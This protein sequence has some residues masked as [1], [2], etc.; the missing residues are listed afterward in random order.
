MIL[1]QESDSRRP[2]LPRHHLSSIESRLI[3][4]IGQYHW[5]SEMAPPLYQKPLSY[6]TGM[7]HKSG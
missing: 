3:F 4:D 6:L 7:A 5:V 2:V 1:A